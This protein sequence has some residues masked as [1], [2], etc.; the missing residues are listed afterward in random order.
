MMM[1][2]VGAKDYESANSLLESCEKFV[3][4]VWEIF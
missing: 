2:Y 4:Y 3:R 1:N